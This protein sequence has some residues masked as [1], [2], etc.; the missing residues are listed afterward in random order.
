MTQNTNVVEGAISLDKKAIDEY[1]KICLKV[2]GVKITDEEAQEEGVRLI[3]MIKAV[4]GNRISLLF[5]KK[6]RKE[7]V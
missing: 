3:R 7:I 2:H 6:K 1:K 5:D 4:Y